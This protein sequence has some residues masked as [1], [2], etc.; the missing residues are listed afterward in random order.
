MLDS[1]S[2]R[3]AFSDGMGRV[4]TTWVMLMEKNFSSR[5]MIEGLSVMCVSVGII[6]DGR[7]L[8]H[9]AL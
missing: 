1:F 3:S 6:H 2:S 8:H 9:L 4:V 7:H 5:Y